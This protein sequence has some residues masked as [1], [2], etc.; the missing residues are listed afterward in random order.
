MTA[1]LDRLESILAQQP[2][3][4]PLDRWQPALCGDIDI[5]IDRQGCWFHQG[6]PIKRQ[7]LVNLFASILRREQDGDY[8]LVTPVEKWRI[9]VEDAALIVVDMDVVQAVM[10]TPIGSAAHEA[11]EQGHG[12][13]EP[14]AVMYAAARGRSHPDLL[15]QNIVFTTNVEQKFLLDA[16]HPLRVNSSAPDGE[17]RPY[18]RVDHGVDALL[19]RAVFYRLVDLALSQASPAPDESALVVWSAGVPHQLT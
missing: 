18:L 7:S 8:Y 3:R 12:A 11:R 10:T 4:P 16:N 5:V 1:D 17:P 14:G 9:R 15:T 19:N 2:Q 13:A 6:Q